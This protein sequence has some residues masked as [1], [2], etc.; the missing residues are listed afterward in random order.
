MNA[1]QCALNRIE[2][3][4]SVQCEHALKLKLKCKSDCL[5]IVICVILILIFL[6]SLNSSFLPAADLHLAQTKL[7]T[8]DQHVIADTW[9]V[10]GV[11]SI[12]L[13][14]ETLAGYY[15]DCTSNVNNGAQLQWSRVLGNNTFVMQKIVNGRRLLIPAET[16]RSSLGLYQCVDTATRE[17]AVLNITDGKRAISTSFF[18]SALLIKFAST[19]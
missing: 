15:M 17:V 18:S 2:C 7:Q 8:S 9:S 10:E 11:A 16:E 1:N 5:F 3:A 4:L 19:Y 13:G 12:E 14:G 6:S